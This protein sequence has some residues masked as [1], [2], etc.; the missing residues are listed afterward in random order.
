LGKLG[1]NGHTAPSFIAMAFCEGLE[2]LNTN[3]GH[4]TV[5]TLAIEI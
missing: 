5:L 1:K 3:E 2:D 4:D